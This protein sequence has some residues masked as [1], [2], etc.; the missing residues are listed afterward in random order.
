VELPHQAERSSSTALLLVTIIVVGIFM[1]SFFNVQSANDQNRHNLEQRATTIAAAL[2]ADQIAKLSG[3]PTDADTQTYKELKSRL[4]ALKQI[5]TD[6]KSIYL[7]GIKGDKVYFMVD[8]E[9]PNTQFYSAPGDQYDEATPAFKNMFYSA[10]VPLVEGPVAD[11]FGS[12][13]SGLAPIFNPHTGRVLAVVGVDVDSVSYN[14][15]LLGALDLPLGSGLILLAVIGVYE[16]SRRRELQQTRMRSELVSIASHELRSPLVG[17]R[18]AIEGLLKSVNNKAEEQKLQAIHDS[19]LHLQD[20]TEDILQFTSLSGNRKLNLAP[21]NM[22]ALVQEICDTQ[23]LVAQQK[24]V[25]LIIDES[26]PKELTITCDADQMKRAMHNLVSNAIKYTRDKTDVVLHYERTV[27]FHRISISDH[28]IGI[29]KAE[30]QRV[31]GGFYRASNAKAS[32]IKGTG[33]GLYL[34]RTILTQ[35]KGSIGF[36]SEEGKGTTFVV[37]LPL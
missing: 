19:I 1:L 22:Q 4:T 3:M 31:F 17:M 25:K 20:G 18:W 30:Q 33:L 2:D 24:G 36:V 27:K 32:G 11:H 21:T 26:W 16:W 12:W 14:Q 8:S 15:S 37:N 7:T 34:T 9:Q 29:P 6:A 13:V 5:N 10:P 28:G 23:S 35:H